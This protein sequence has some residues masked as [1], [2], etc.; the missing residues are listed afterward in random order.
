MIKALI[1]KQ[2]MEMFSFVRQ[3]KKKNEIRTGSEL[4]L[5]AVLY[6]V[7]FAFL[8]G[9]FAFLALALCVPF[10]AAGMSWLY[11]AIMGLTAIAMGAFGSVFNTY[12][13]LYLPK[14]NSMLLAMPI[15]PS[16]LLFARLAGVYVMGLMY[17]L[18]VMIPTLIVY[19]LFGNPG[20][21]GIIFS[22]IITLVISV[23]VL[24]LSTLL[25]FVVA[26]ISSKIKRKSFITV[27]L[28]LAFIAAYYYLYSQA[29]NMI[30]NIITAPQIA[31]D[32]IKNSI[33][34]LYQMGMGAQGDVNAFLIFTAMVLAL[35]GIV[36][37]VL[38]K[39]YTKIAITN[40]GGVKKVYKEQAM[41]AGSVN[42]ALFRK[43]VR[44]FIGSPSYMLN[45][46]LGVV[47]MLV[48][49]GALLI[50]SGD[51][52]YML[53]VVFGTGSGLVPL[54]ACAAICFIS[55]MNDITAPSVSLEG[56]NLWIVQT[57]PV[58]GWQILAAKLNLHLAVTLVPVLIL[59]AS[60]EFVI[61]PSIEYAV[62]IPIVAVL[63]VLLIAEL[64]L[65]INLLSPNLNW[66]DENVPIKQSVGVM[67]ALFSGWVIVLALGVVYFFVAGF[68]TPLVYMIAV[69][70]LL[71]AATLVLY[72]WLKNKGARIIENL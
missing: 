51:I 55:G 27:F 52:A 64:G 66:T 58:S 26:L 11:F 2:M 71:A 43:E 65:F 36:Y 25:G 5:T 29:F 48:A 63:F 12:S 45:C 47:L 30:E 31:G 70:L 40:K 54:I 35:F 53:D 24:T 69:A 41:K 50:N 44:R 37:F 32:F 34:P 62:L 57:F 72:M 8:A 49:A 39:T 60:V 38:S 22:I 56:K 42:G 13:S 20:I 6:I 7:L 28:S 46:G 23:F 61:K 68:V 59:T 19:F 10:A 1:K 14:D 4:V 17:E 3:N 18:L 33:Y 15:K 67:A 16:V 21:L 9:M